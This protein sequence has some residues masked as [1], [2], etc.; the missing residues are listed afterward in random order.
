VGG[1]DE[2]CDVLDDAGRVVG[3]ATRAEVRAGNLWHRTVFVAVVTPAG[4]IVAH[5]RADWKDVWPSYWDL[6]FGGLV[7]AG[8]S[9][10]PAAVRELAE[11]SGVHVGTDELELLDEGVFDRSDVRERCRIYRVHSAGPFVPADGEVAAIE[12]VPLA[13]LTGWLAEHEIVPDTLDLLV[14]LLTG[15]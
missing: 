13:S 6:C 3:V 1:A 11:E 9:W 8:E 10:L 12:L 15:D 7:G 5:R 2:L 4:E 14:P